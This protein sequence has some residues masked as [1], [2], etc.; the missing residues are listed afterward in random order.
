MLF[1]YPIQATASNWLH[2]CIAEM[3]RSSLI[4]LNAGAQA[5]AW[6]DIIPHA[7]RD[8]LNRRRG[9]RKRLEKFIEVISPFPAAER[10]SLLN[11][12]NSQNNFPHM[13]DGLTNCSGN[14]ALPPSILEAVDD[15]MRFSFDLLSQLRIRDDH[16]K[17]IHA[18]IPS[19]V[20]PFC[21][22]E[23]FEAPGAPRHHLDHYLPISRYPFAGANL[24]NLVPMGDRCNS[25]YKRNQDILFDRQGQ[26]RRCY[27]PYGQIVSAVSLAQS[28]PFEGPDGRLPVWVIELGQSMEA[29]T[30]NDVWDI[31]RR[32]SRDV[33]D[34]EYCNWL[35]HFAQWC[36]AT[37]RHPTN[38]NEIIEALTAFVGT[39]I[40]EGFSDRAFLKRAVFEMLRDHATRSERVAFFLID[41]ASAD[42]GAAA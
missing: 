23:Y 33:L 31:K 15:L 24:R 27:D 11:A 22:C 14:S 9:L 42:M 38:R 32:Y 21:G 3:V 1:G 41:V 35:D 26:R 7:H 20:C 13:F 10:M 25:A 16:Y 30:W 28:R 5:I 40:P 37:E 19:R 39:V 8:R 29:E 18:D 34:G 17:A 36:R 6:P 4:A 2:D 12:F